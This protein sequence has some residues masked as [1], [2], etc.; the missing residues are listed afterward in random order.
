MREAFTKISQLSRVCHFIQFFVYPLAL[1]NVIRLL[2]LY[3]VVRLF[4]LHVYFSLM[5]FCTQIGCS[6]MK[7]LNLLSFCTPRGGCLWRQ[8]LCEYMIDNIIYKSIVVIIIDKVSKNSTDYWSLRIK[9]CRG[10]ELFAICSCFPLH[11]EINIE[12]KWI[13]Q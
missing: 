2:Q 7:L 12:N 3:C 9:N 4:S 1:T 11:E 13:L 5:F 10:N 8:L 6:F